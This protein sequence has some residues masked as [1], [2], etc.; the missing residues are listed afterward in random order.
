MRSKHLAIKSICAAVSLLM[1]VSCGGGGGNDS[2]QGEVHVGQFVDGPVS[3]LYYKTAT[4]SGVTNSNGD[5]QY[6]DGETITFYV[7]NMSLP[8]MPGSAM[9]TP[10]DYSPLANDASYPS[11]VNIIRLL[12]SLDTDLDHSNG[13]QLPGSL[14]DLH[15]LPDVEP[16][17]FDTSVEQFETS[18]Q[19]VAILGENSLSTL[20]DTQVAVNNF[21]PIMDERINQI[22]VSAQNDS[23]HDPGAS[24]TTNGV[25]SAYPCIPGTGPSDSGIAVGDISVRSIYGNPAPGTSMPRSREDALWAN[26]NYLENLHKL[27]S[28]FYDTYDIREF[29][30]DV[31]VGI[32]NFV[33]TDPNPKSITPGWGHTELKL[34]GTYIGTLPYAYAPDLNIGELSVST[35]LYNGYPRLQDVQAR[36][37]LM[38]SSH[39]ILVAPG[40]YSWSAIAY[41]DT[42]CNDITGTNPQCTGQWVYTPVWNWP[43]GQIDI[44]AGECLVVNATGEQ[45][46]TEP[47]VSNDPHHTLVSA[48]FDADEGCPILEVLTSAGTYTTDGS[49]EPNGPDTEGCYLDY[50][51]AR[52]VGGNLI[53]GGTAEFYCNGSFNGPIKARVRSADGCDYF[54]T[55]SNYSVTNSTRISCASGQV[56]EGVVPNW[57]DCN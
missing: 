43:G 52:M 42:W 48:T 55:N 13:I 26:N 39:Q 36:C 29:A 46:T 24:C 22:T 51:Y 47:P 5:Y 1:V 18:P 23:E 2:T 30:R 25:V 54:G 16:L 7:G 49:I 45:V 21:Q 14:I 44:H 57:S 28:V 33:T 27:A 50:D 11:I 38:N 19:V 31:N 34:D 9:I 10:A 12:Q 17:A 20:I 40:T 37:G 6:R 4:L 15:T 56:Q 53:P 3:G 41:Q 32:V 35:L 8:P